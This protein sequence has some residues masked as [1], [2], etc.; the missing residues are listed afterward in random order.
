MSELFLAVITGVSEYIC[1][2]V[3]KVLLDSWQY[4]VRGARRDTTNQEI[5]D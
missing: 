2:W 3:S 1:N 5:L 4:R